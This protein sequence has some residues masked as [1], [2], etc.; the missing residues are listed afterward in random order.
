MKKE[1]SV[2]LH[3]ARVLL[4][5]EDM[6]ILSLLIEIQKKKQAFTLTGLRE[7][8]HISHKSLIIH[9]KRMVALGLIMSFPD[10]TVH[11]GKILQ[12]TE[13]G[14]KVF[15]LIEDKVELWK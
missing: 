2:R 6:R 13:T 8:M 12:I 1:L 10:P 11:R 15:D 3:R 9:T 4:D 14:K 7:D 5:I